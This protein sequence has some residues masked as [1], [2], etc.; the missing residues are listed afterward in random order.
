M[1]FNLKY[2]FSLTG[3]QSSATYYFKMY[4]DGFVGSA[5]TF[6]SG[7]GPRNAITINTDIS[8][9]DPFFPSGRRCAAL[10]YF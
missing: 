2:R 1:A 9:Q 5:R 8:E 3:N 10:T 4:E 7:W 6:S